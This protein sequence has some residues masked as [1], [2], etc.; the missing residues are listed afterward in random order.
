MRLDHIFVSEDIR[1]IDSAVL[2]NKL[3][4]VASDHLPLIADLILTD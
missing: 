3:T 1:V 2:Q 4:R